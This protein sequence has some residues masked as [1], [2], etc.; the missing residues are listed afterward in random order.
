MSKKSV[1]DIVTEKVVEFLE[2]GTIPWRKPWNGVDGGNSPI[3]ITGRGYN[4]INFFLLS[5]LGFDSPIFL[6]FKQIQERGG[7]IKE[8]EEKKHFPVFF[9]A[10]NK[11]STDKNGNPLPEARTIPMCRYYLVWNIE[12]TTLEV[13]EKLKSDQTKSVI[14]NYGTIEAAET[15]VNG[16]KNA[17]KITVKD[18]SNVACYYPT[19]DIVNVPHKNQFHSLEE[20]Y[21]VL[22]HELTHST[23]H[24][25]R[26]NR[27]EL[28]AGT[29]FGSH[30]YSVE[31]L[32]AE[33][34]AAFLCNHVGINNTIENSAAY[35]KGWLSKLKS[36]PK[37][38]MTAASRA[39]KAFERITGKT[40]DH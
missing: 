22:F 36:D 27:K 13:P 37:M 19:T 9:W 21:G 11:Y 12:Q 18:G 6:T 30:D 34:G 10:F 17:P 33:M 14:A 26:L 7:K 3:N 8:G 35:I 32:V 24:A 25:S 29:Y 2:K 40:T 1:F 28:M 31:E 5:C 23:G 16:Y 38:L 4:G 20:Y 15:V 39:Q